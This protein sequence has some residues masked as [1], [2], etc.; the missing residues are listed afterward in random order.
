MG[1]KQKYGLSFRLIKLATYITLIFIVQ[2]S[3]SNHA[4]GQQRKQ[5][6]WI[7]EKKSNI[8]RWRVGL[9]AHAGEPTGA[10]VQFYKLKGI[11]SQTV[12]I[13]KRLSFDLSVSREGY[14]LP[15]LVSNNSSLWEKGGIRLGVDFR[16]HF[17]TAY[18]IP[19]LGIGAESGSRNFSGVSEFTHDIVSR[20]GF[21]SKLLGLRTSTKSMFHISYFLEGKYN[22]GLNAPF[23]YISPSI[24]LRMHFL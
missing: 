4:L 14:I 9:G 17:P 2:S 5:A 23:S 20:I 8:T 12:R 13:K 15:Q 6:N 19:Y 21:E 11:C 1:N 10:S 22:Y 16:F 24:G 7:E 18:L 3:F